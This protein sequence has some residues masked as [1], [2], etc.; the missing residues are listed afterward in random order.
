M[1]EELRGGLLLQ[2][3]GWL[4]WALPPSLCY[5]QRWTKYTTSLLVWNSQI[6]LNYKEKLKR[7]IFT[8]IKCYLF[9]KL[10]DYQNSKV[11]VNALFYYCCI[12]T[13]PYASEASNLVKP[14]KPI[15]IKQLNW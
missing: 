11:N 4:M 2:Q 12:V 15:E 8:W 7:P 14:T 10:G 6:L 3:G 1:P 9:L 5:M 13:V